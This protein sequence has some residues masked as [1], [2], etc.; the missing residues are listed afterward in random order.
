MLALGVGVLLA[1][2]GYWVPALS[3]FYKL[4]WFT[5]FLIAFVLY[6]FSYKMM[7]LA[8]AVVRPVPANPMPADSIT[9]APKSEVK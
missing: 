3:F 4:S 7:N 8:P 9:I 1:L 6:Y 2:I 5:G